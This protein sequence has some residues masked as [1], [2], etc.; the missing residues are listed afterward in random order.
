MNGKDVT[1]SLHRLGDILDMLSF[2]TFTVVSPAVHSGRDARRQ[3]LN[4]N[5]LNMHLPLTKGLQV[6]F[7]RAQ[8]PAVVVT[9][10]HIT[11]SKPLCTE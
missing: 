4:F 2:F 9:S 1:S 11:D 7:L 3:L 10:R 8:M 5:G 6:P